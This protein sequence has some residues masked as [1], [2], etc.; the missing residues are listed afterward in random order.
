MVRVE[1]WFWRKMKTHLVISYQVANPS[2]TNVKNYK[3]SIG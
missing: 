3:G 1:E 2:K